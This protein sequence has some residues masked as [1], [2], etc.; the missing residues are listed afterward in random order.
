MVCG[1]SES[2][3]AGGSDCKGKKAGGVEELTL[4]STE[5]GTLTFMR[6]EEKLA[7]DV[8]LVMFAC[9]GSKIF[10][11]I[12]DSEQNHMD[13]IKTL[14]DKYGLPDPVYQE[15]GVFN[16]SNLQ[17]LYEQLESQGEV[18]KLDALMVGA[19]IEEIDIEDLQTAIDQTDRKDLQRVYRNLMNCSENHL[20]AF[21]SQIERLGVNYEVQHLPQE[22]VD[23]ILAER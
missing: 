12:A 1:L 19:L 22:I 23:E 16:D 18:S 3:L 2:V 13:A 21:V 8:Y 5:A 17:E 6:E 20:R 9:W 4:S 7:R 11:N 15:I 10:I 14:L